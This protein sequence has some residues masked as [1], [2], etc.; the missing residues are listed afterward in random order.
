MSTTSPTHNP[1]RRRVTTHPAPVH[2]Y[3]SPDRRHRQS[4]RNEDA[5][6][7]APKHRA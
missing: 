3:E 5:S 4:P 7:Q 6:L 2:E 1:N